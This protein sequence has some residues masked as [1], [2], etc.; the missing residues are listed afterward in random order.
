MP[1]CTAWSRVRTST[2]QLTRPR[3]EVVSAG[4][5]DVP[6]AGVGDDDDVGRR[7]RRGARRSSRSSESEPNSSSPSTNTHHAD[8]QR[9]AEG[10]QRRDVRHDAGLV[11][12]GAPAVEPAVALDR[13]ERVGLPQRQVA[14][15][16]DVVVGVEQHGRRAGRA[17]PGGRSPRAGRPDRTMST[18]QAAA[19]QQLGDRLGGALHVR[20]VEARRTRCRGCGRGA[21]GR[22]GRR[23]SPAST[24]ARTSD[25]DMIGEVMTGIVCRPYRGVPAEPVPSPPPAGPVPAHAPGAARPAG[26]PAGCLGGASIQERARPAVPPTHSPRR[27]RRRRAGAAARPAGPASG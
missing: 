19:A 15:R 26:V 3:S 21:P 14:D 10:A 7:A 13:L 24:A 2:K 23:A 4:Y 12:G 16:L 8:R 11:V 17:R 5:A 20:V 1:L 27:W 18:S 6:V 9:V 25:S 22:R